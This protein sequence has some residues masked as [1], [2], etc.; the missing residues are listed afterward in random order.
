M[1]LGKTLQAIALLI[2]RQERGPQLVVAPTSVCFGWQR[3]MERFA[4]SLRPRLLAGTERK[5]L[6]DELGPRDVVVTSWGVL[7]RDSEELA[8]VRFA[9]F[10]MD[11][12]QAIKNAATRRARAARD[13]DAERR[14]A[15]TGTPLENHL[16]ELWA[17]FRAAAPG[18]LGSWEQFKARFAVPIE[19]H[20]DERARRALSRLIRP[21]LLRRTKAEVAEDLPSRTEVVHLV[22]LSDDER[23]AY[24]DVRLAMLAKLEG[25]EDKL[26]GGERHNTDKRFEI[27]SALT[28]LRMRACHPVLD[29]DAVDTPSSKLKSVLRIASDLKDGGHRALVFS[30]FTSHLGLVRRALEEQGFTTLYLDGS[31]PQQ[32][33]ARL[34]DRFQAGEGDLFLISLKAGG[35]G[36]NLTAADYVLLLD[37]WW[38]PAV[39]DQAADRTHRIG[40]TRPVTIY[41]L[42]ARDTI[43][44]AILSLQADKRRLVDDVL[45]GSGSAGALSTSELVALI[46]RHGHMESHLVPAT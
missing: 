23:R 39:E 2:D 37:P 11:E 1:G 24:E 15:L 42:V 41:K 8:K 5:G 17:I 40:Q 22:E 33:R 7:L 46:E 13:V 36:L 26:K 44:E 19:R 28:R 14:L 4:P 18:L 34:V 10:V 25:E 35:F 38:N 43:E 31:T 32:E 6:L 12:A 45:D 9:T 27:L 29:G 21:F 20:R 30:Q 3:E 16:G